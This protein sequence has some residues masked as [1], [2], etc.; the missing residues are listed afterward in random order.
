MES[1]TATVGKATQAVYPLNV[2]TKT[3]V[4]HVVG[5]DL[6]DK[7]VTEKVVQEVVEMENEV[8]HESATEPP[9]AIGI[10]VTST[11]DF[12]P[13]S[14][15]VATPNV[16]AP[17][18][19]ILV[20]TA[21]EN[22]LAT[23]RH[24]IE[25]RHPLTA[26]GKEDDVDPTHYFP[27]AQVGSFAESGKG[28]PITSNTKLVKAYIR[29]RL[30][31]DWY[32]NVGNVAGTC[33]FSW[34]IAYMGFGWWALIGVFFVTAS[35][36]RA[37]SRRFQRNVRDDLLR[38]T[39]HET[40][41]ERYE[42]VEWLNTL[43][44]KIWI[45]Y[46]PV[47]SEKTKETANP[48]LA[49]AA[50]GYGIDTL[51]LDEFTLGTKAPMIES[52]RSY[53]KKSESFTEMDWKFSFMPSDE[54]NMTP[55]EAKHK[56][57]PKISLGVSVGKG[58]VSKSLPVLVE[59]INVAGNLRVT[60][61]YGDVFPNIKTVSVS[62]LEPPLI[63]FALKPVGGDTL[64]LDIMTFLPGL[65]TFVK[66]MIDSF[67]RPMLYAPN[68]FDID[69]EEI[70]AAQSSDAIGVVAVT[71]HSAQ[72][73]KPSNSL[74]SFIELTTDRP[75]TTV[76]EEVRTKTQ[77]NTPTWSETKYLMVNSLEQ[78]L[79]L[80]CFNA[81]GRKNNL[82]GEAVFELNEL[83]QKSEQ[84]GLVT[85]LKNNGKT[86]GALKYDLVWHPVIGKEKKPDIPK[87]SKDISSSVDEDGSTEVE[88]QDVEN[89]E[90]EEEKS[91]SLDTGILK[92]TLHKVKYLNTGS[93]VTGVLSPSADLF[94]DEK[95]QKYYK[96][97][98]RMNEPTWEESIEIFV[99]SRRNSEISLKIYD[100]HV[101]GREMICEYSSVIDQFLEQAEEGKEFVKG[102]PQGEIYFTAV[103][104]PV[105]VPE[106]AFGASNAMHDPL[107]VARL[108]IRDA[109][110]SEP[111][112]S[113]DIDT[114]FVVSTDKTVIYK[115]NYFAKNPEPIFNNV[116]YVPIT[117]DNQIV[118]I[119]LYDFQ[120]IGKDR[121]I[122]GCHF[123][124][125]NIM[126]GDF[127]TGKLQPAGSDNK[128]LEWNLC[129][130]ER[131]V[132][133]NIVRTSVTFI[134]TISVFAP[135]EMEKVAE[136]EK[137]VIEKEKKFEAEQEALR[138]EMEENPDE[139]EIVEID[140]DDKEAALL[141]KKE[142]M[143]FEELIKYN[144]GVISFRVSNGKLHKGSHLQILCDEFPYPAFVSNKAN[145]GMIAA[146]HGEYFVRDLQ[147][148]ITCFRVT[149][150][151]I[152]KDSDDVVTE[153]NIPTLRLLTQS[154]NEPFTV[155]LKGSA[156]D[157]EMIYSPTTITLPLSETIVDTGVMEIEVV[158][159]ANLPSHD[160]NGLSDPFAVIKLDGAKLFTTET[161]KK[162]LSPS[163]NAKTTIPIPS[164]ARNKLVIE[165][166]D[167]DRAG[168]NTLLCST[169]LS[170]TALSINEPQSFTL[171]LTPQGMV[172]VRTLFKP[173]YIRPAVNVAEGSLV[174][175]PFKA[176]GTVANFGI[177]VAGAGVGVATGAAGTV[178]D[179]GIGGIQ[180][181]GR[182]L[183]GI[184]GFNNKHSKGSSVDGS[185][186]PDLPKI[187]VESHDNEPPN[188]VPKL[189]VAPSSPVNHH[190]RRLS[191]AINSQVES[192]D[193]RAPGATSNNSDVLYELSSVDGP[194]GPI[195]RNRAF[196]RTSSF[197]RGVPAHANIRGSLTLIAAENL[198]KSV[199]I[200][201]SLV[202]EGKLKHV[203][204]TEKQKADANG[205]CFFNETCEF[206]APPEANLIFSAVSHH[207]FSKDTKLGVAQVN[208]A[209]PQLR[210]DGQI[211]IKLGTG[212][213]I[214][215]L[216][217]D[218]GLPPVP[219][220]PA[221]LQQTLK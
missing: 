190:N 103:W 217:Y 101:T 65:K 115:S 48:Q 160:R 170:L 86:K 183:K 213:I 84:R 60:L 177:G 125:G 193:H 133:A 175:M 107:G 50:P 69:V 54:S 123:K 144:S 76:D 66:T 55:H 120:R 150:V 167:W 159:A 16:G 59:D 64:G 199:Q 92:F 140:V 200:R 127:A 134:P 145:N 137:R 90:E 202:R 111:G 6:G 10:P 139:Y 162:T 131:N 204:R 141:N 33:I 196:S 158:S 151:P 26:N 114:Y 41:A 209:D 165:V 47:I 95:K 201:I 83:Y 180:K 27:W 173:E 4:Q 21:Q 1:T 106:G 195:P 57:K 117:S 98:R 119:D 99:P 108:H 181:G 58:I 192:D 93:S 124:A 43:L 148:S 176:V 20:R 109:L 35:V 88:N 128:I 5:E 214:F 2:Q 19:K 8:P 169:V 164:R 91:K 40:L 218:G 210:Q 25:K 135:N 149:S 178:A 42:S 15:N 221:E 179:L 161:I 122:G 208:L 156:V 157:V 78:K 110:V 220:L 146:E 17:H 132:T 61:H 82:I 71:L 85:D 81:A 73:L 56:V 105:D 46:M 11:N 129:D 29:E 44:S 24:V 182:L 189:S 75:V 7:I 38:T 18:E 62:L 49:G 174:S 3:K 9:N 185:E 187:K 126:A 112:F 28:S 216:Q 130:K 51:S 142:K 143:S 212:H 191:Q 63:D 138:K 219:A 215:K 97:L 154:Y 153:I 168:S 37:T 104:K 39:V 147:H 172:N 87:M 68:H 171:D 36:Y 121:F 79:Y 32:N 100:E 94:I 53:P 205:T 163:W 14:M 67:A 136:L 206:R 23:P 203:Y 118:T 34:F 188:A 80:K 102:N 186:Q 113:G 52:I 166:Y 116:I 22:V 155:G 12:N 45:I 30:Y 184:G 13:K 197:S 70:M 72:G 194:P 152:V 96:T 31:N 198:G 211:L 89:S 77:R 207:T 74:N